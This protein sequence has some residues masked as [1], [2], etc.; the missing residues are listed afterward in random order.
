MVL[1]REDQVPGVS[2]PQAIG[3]AESR[4]GGHSPGMGAYEE[5]WEGAVLAV[6]AVHDHER[7][8]ARAT[9]VPPPGRPER[10]RSTRD[11]FQRFRR[12]DRHWPSRYRPCRSA[13]PA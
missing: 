13:R 5:D 9:V 8:A 4:P 2:A 12:S 7:R 10:E 3:F 1:D 6:G 11:D